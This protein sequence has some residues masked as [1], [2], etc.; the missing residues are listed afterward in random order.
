[1]SLFSDVKEAVI[2][3]RFVIGAH[4]DDR[5]R[6]REIMGWQVAAGVETAQLVQVCADARPNPVVE[7]QQELAD[8]TPIKAVWAWL[9]ADREAKLVTVHLL[10]R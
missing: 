3:G 5:L 8:G 9:A 2:D 6:E 7:L 10:E 1:V 4:A